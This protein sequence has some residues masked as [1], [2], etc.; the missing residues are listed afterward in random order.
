VQAF[1]RGHAGLGTFKA[2]T[3][4]L[5]LPLNV[6]LS[7]HCAHR[8]RGSWRWNATKHHVKRAFVQCALISSTPDCR[9]RNAGSWSAAKQFGAD[10]RGIDKV[11]LGLV[12]NVPAQAAPS[13]TR[14]RLEVMRGCDRD[15]A[16]V[17]HQPIVASR[18]ILVHR[19]ARRDTPHS[20]VVRRHLDFVHH[21]GHV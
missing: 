8:D 7:R 15:R 21:H 14:D 10:V 13:N 16:C 12:M 17:L 6:S 3:R 11:C 2:G 18:T 1:T 4:H 9:V 20:N 19:I 5:C